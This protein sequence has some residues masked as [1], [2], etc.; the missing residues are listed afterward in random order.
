MKEIVFRAYRP[1]TQQSCTCR[2]CKERKSNRLYTGQGQSGHYETLT[3][4]EKAKLPFI[5]DASTVVVVTHGMKL[6]LDDPVDAANWKWLQRHPYI[7]ID[8]DKGIH[9]TDTV[10]YV[11]NV[12]KEAEERVSKDKKRTLAKGKVY[13]ASFDELIKVAKS[14]D[15]PSPESFTRPM[16]EDWMVDKCHSMPAAVSDT[17][18]PENS[19]IVNARIFFNELTRHAILTRHGGIY[20]MNGEKGTVVGHSDE[21][22]LEFILEEK[23]GETVKALRAMLIEKK[24]VPTEPE[25]KKLE[26]VSESA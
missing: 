18:N 24:P 2:P 23:N 11:E 1:A 9:I 16:L 6:N 5:I 26:E 15:H 10:F 21:A 22:V 25:P 4:E 20:R 13:A 3:T 14:L 7:A 12:E 19:A 17:F 8:K